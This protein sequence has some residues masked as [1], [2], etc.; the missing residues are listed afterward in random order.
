[1]NTYQI[2]VRGQKPKTGRS[3]EHGPDTYVAILT[4]PDGAVIPDVLNRHVLAKRGIGIDQI[5]EG[6]SRHRGPRSMLGQA[7]A[8]AEEIVR[9][10]IRESRQAECAAQNCPCLSRQDLVG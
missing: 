4:V 10:R 8:L 2:I 5:G 1:M 6:Y 9:A 7:I 3:G